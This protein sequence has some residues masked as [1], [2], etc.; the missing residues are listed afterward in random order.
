MLK[1]KRAFLLVVS[2]LL[3]TFVIADNAGLLRIRTDQES[4]WIYVDG[5]KKARTTESYVGV[6][7][8]EGEHETFIKTICNE[9]KRKV[10]VG[11]GVVVPINFVLKW[12]DP[13]KG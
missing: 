5:E 10:F 6:E 1:Q 12:Q 2:V 9:K 7:V 11:E 3:T 13:V 8:L 4:A